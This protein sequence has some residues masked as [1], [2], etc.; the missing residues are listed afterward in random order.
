M[1]SLEVRTAVNQAVADATTINTYD[2]SDYVTLED[3]L[4]SID[5]EAV[6]IQYITSGERI[7]SIGGPNNQGWEEDGSVVLHL[8]VPTG[9]NSGPTIATGDAIRSQLKGKRITPN[10]TIE[11]CDPFTDYGAGSTGLYGGAWKG[12]ASNLY[13]VNRSCG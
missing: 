5:S 10:I 11:A 13:Y 1:S 4:S 8:V 3:C 6:L 9:F 2:I 12:Y 7:A